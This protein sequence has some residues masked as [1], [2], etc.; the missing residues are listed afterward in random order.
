MKT[1]PLCEYGIIIEVIV[2]SIKQKVYLC[3]ECDALWKKDTINLDEVLSFDEFMR[4]RNLKPL[5]E[6]LEIIG[7]L[8]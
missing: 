3:E 7:E 6:E 8:E 2:K 5:W 1:C 4:E